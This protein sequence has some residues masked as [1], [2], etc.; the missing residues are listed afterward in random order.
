MAYTSATAAGTQLSAAI[1]E[2]YSQE[3]LFS[4]Q[5]F[6]LFEQFVTRREELGK[7]PGQTINFLRYNSL[8]GSD[9]LTELT[10]MTINAITGSQVQIS[11]AEH[12]FAVGM[13][14]LLR[15][16]SF[17]D[18]LSS[19]AKLLGMHMGKSR[20][21]LIRDVFY[22][23][24]NVAYA[25]G[26]TGRAS[27]LATDTFSVDLVREGV[28][29]LAVNKCPKI[30]NEYICIIHPR[31]AKNLRKDKDWVNASNYGA[32]GQLFTG[33]LGRIDDVRF[34]QTT[35]IRRILSTDGSIYTDNADTGVNAG[36]YSS[37]TDVYSAVLLGDYAVGLA[38]AREAELRDN[39]VTDFGRKQE[40]AYYGLWGAGIVE[41]GHAVI[42]ESA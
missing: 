3:V 36:T 35:Q 11:V 32:P 15:D 26:K 19:A 34:L 28:E 1:M 17:D 31:Q 12:G 33:E 9:S 2:V 4:A 21:A 29:Q 14:Q 18:V 39:G 42:L 22:G 38:V 40:L 41:S 7:Q 37:N 5:P 24:S 23:F 8:S 13:T 6:M 20:D 16:V 30:G 25:G 27:L 10:D